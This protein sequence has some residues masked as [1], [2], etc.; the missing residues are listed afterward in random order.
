MMLAPALAILIS[1]FAFAAGSLT[2]SGA[3]AAA[4][5]GTLC[6]LAGWSWAALLLVY[7]VVAVAC[8]RLGADDKE[9]RT[10]GVVAKGGQRDAVQVLANGG[11]FA[12]AA[13]GSTH[14]DGAPAMLL[15]A[16]ALGALAA[17][18]ADTLATEIGTLMGG[19]PRSLLSWRHVPAGT[20]GGVTIV[21]S[22]GML[23]GALLVA[24]AACALMPVHHVLA[25]AAGGVTG[26]LAD[27]VL[28]AVV[29]ARRHCPQCDR[30]TERRVH[31]CGSL[32]THAGGLIWLDND[33]VNLCAT[34]VGA[35]VAATLAAV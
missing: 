1:A 31:D 27:S 16:A 23:V 22:L 15:A 3:L 28:G 24:G 6:I 20:S 25:A 7:F 33:L 11:V 32:T 13:F 9:R 21:G 18:S 19:E 5:V 12:V 17:A 29:Q 34:I 14:A 8:S 26:A 35:A 10:A 30:A 4:V 2:L